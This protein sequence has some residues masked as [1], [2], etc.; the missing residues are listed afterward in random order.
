MESMDET[1]EY[2]GLEKKYLQ[3]FKN[4]LLKAVIWIV[5]ICILIIIEFYFFKQMFNSTQSLHIIYLMQYPVQMNS[6]V[7]FTFTSIVK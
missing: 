4:S 5:M 6:I 7:D 1:L 2:L 3:I